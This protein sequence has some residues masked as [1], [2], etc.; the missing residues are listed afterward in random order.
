MILVMCTSI[1][2]DTLATPQQFG[3]VTVAPN[4]IF[5]VRS[6]SWN[7]D[8]HGVSFPITENNMY[9]WTSTG[10]IQLLIRA[11]IMYILQAIGGTCP[12]YC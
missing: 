1:K 9:L 3:S 5:M 2:N 4:T 11:Q 7:G 8:T 6:C 12:L 10:A